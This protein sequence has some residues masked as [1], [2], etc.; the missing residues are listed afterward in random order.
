MAELKSTK[1]LKEK[2]LLAILIEKEDDLNSLKELELLANTAGLDVLGQIHQKIKP[3]NST[4]FGSGKLEEIDALIKADD[5]DVLVCDN[6]LSP[7]QVRNLNKIL[8]IKI[9]DRPTL[10][11]DIFA[12]R[13]SSQ[14]GKLQVELAQLKYNLPRL[15][16]VNGVLDKYGGGVGMRGPGEKKLETDKR[17]IRGQI[18]VLSKQ[19]EK[20]TQERELRRKKR[21]DNGIKSV[22]LVGYTNAG[23]S[24]VMNLLSKSGE[25][26]KDML[27]AT[28]DPTT[29]KVFVDVNKHYILTDTVGFIDKLPHEFIDAF[30]STLEEARIADVLLHVLDISDPFLFER[31][32]TV[33][34]VL[35]YLKINTNN[36]ITIYNKVDK[37][38]EIPALPV[39]HDYIIL[40][41]NDSDKYFND[42]QKIITDKLF[43]KKT[44]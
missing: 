7:T 35:E 36:V 24:T 5:I 2:A 31:Y 20:L 10:I 30:S 4:L 32:D 21:Y 16:G 42:L 14:E 33:M 11:L 1:P 9:I 6:S 22:A 28:L 38:T 41:A 3:I 18:D 15:V 37:V 39:N 12:M 34:S 19:I 13:A 29:R 25:T 43:E 44:D 23:K 17:R 27:F 26:P 40:S 8:G